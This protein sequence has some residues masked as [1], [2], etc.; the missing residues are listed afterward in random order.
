MPP[1][2]LKEGELQKKLIAQ[3]LLNYLIKNGVFT[4][5]IEELQ[6]SPAKIKW[7][8]SLQPTVPPYSILPDRIRYVFKSID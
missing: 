4:T 2:T 8:L 1:P 7:I 3:K 5:Q 6:K